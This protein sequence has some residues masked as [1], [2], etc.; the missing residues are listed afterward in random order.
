[1]AAP[2]T[3]RAED[4]RVWRRW[5]QENAASGGDVWLLFYKKHVRKP[6]VSYD[7]AVE[8]ALCFRWI[9]GIV[10]RVDDESYMQRF[11]PRKDGSKW[12]TSN[13]MRMKALM[14]SGLVT[15][16]GMKVYDSRSY[17]RPE[18]EKLADQVRDIM[19]VLESALKK[20]TMA[21]RNYS[22]FA[23]SHKRRYGLWV[24]TAKKPETRDERI[25]EAV[26]LIAKNEKELLK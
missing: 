6:S 8:E 19:P 15:A 1:M 22:K 7:E 25:E 12:S 16:A 9:D 11:M 13:L 5:L 4:R 18:A 20:N 3:L 21:W 10:R 17:E 23:P 26:E 2:P 24:A 14:E